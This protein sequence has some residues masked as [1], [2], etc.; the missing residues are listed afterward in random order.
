MLGLLPLL[1]G[2]GSPGLLHSSPPPE[3]DLVGGKVEKDGVIHDLFVK[4][5]TYRNLYNETREAYEALRETY[6]TLH[7]THRELRDKTL[8]LR[9][10]EEAYAMFR[11]RE[12][13]AWSRLYQEAGE[14]P[15]RNT[16]EKP[17]ESFPILPFFEPDDV[18]AE[19]GN[20]WQR[21]RNRY[22]VYKAHY[23]RVK[24]A[25]ALLKEAKEAL[26]A[27]LDS[28]GKEWEKAQTTSADTRSLYT[29]EREAWRRLYND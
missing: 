13:K 20:L 5:R 24:N 28:A 11:M 16:V 29:R 4:V 9:E 14:D 21:L 18:S 17:E 6:E 1:E 3:K 15:S 22:K 23:E 10:N 8:L 7:A 2:A 27:D 19:A 25:Y 12:K 26:Q